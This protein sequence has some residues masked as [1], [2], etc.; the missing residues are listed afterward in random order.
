M[1]HRTPRMA[2]SDP[3]DILRTRSLLVLLVTLVA[4]VAVPASA[5]AAA[6]VNDNFLSPVTVNPDGAGTPMP[7]NVSVEWVVGGGSD[8]PGNINQATTQTGGMGTTP[9]NV[10]ENLSCAGIPN[11]GKT[12]WYWAFPDVSGWYQIRTSG[13]DAVLRILALS[14]GSN[15]G[16]PV[17]PNFADSVCADDISDENNEELFVGVQGGPGR[18][19]AIQVGVYNNG[20]WPTATQ[21][22]RV[23]FFRD[24]DLDQTFDP[25]DRCPTTAG[26]AN[27]Q[28]CPDSDGDG[29]VNIDDR[30][31]TVRGPASLRGCPDGDGDG[32]ADVDDR[33]PSQNARARDANGDGCLDPLPPPPIR[34]LDRTVLEDFGGFATASTYRITKFLIVGVPRGARISAKCLKPKRRGK[35]RRSCGSQTI[36]K[37][38]VSSAMTPEAQAAKTRKLKKFIGKRLR[39]GSTITV[40][41]TASNAIGRYIRISIV[42]KGRFLGKKVFRG[43]MNRGAKTKFRRRGCR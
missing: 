1:L 2:Q 28:G 27:T 37:A 12:V 31:P 42:R 6:P 26:P 32:V 16:N 3:K 40:R 8:P 9:V 19:Y 5:L 22:T 20:T 25:N 34:R 18:R 4:L 11:F 13:G 24:R 30:C 41:V 23:T 15:V 35:R 36:R 29:V 7:H 43:C 21:L 17:T 38:T 39:R 14:N 10:A 33:C